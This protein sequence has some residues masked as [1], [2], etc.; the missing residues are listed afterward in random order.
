MHFLRPG[1]EE[2][3]IREAAPLKKFLKKKKLAASQG[4]SRQN[5]CVERSASVV[6]G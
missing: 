4:L 5:L 6:A 1:E 3:Q 2:I